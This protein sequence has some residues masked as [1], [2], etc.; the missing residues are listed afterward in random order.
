MFSGFVILYMKMRGLLDLEQVL[1]QVML[2]LWLL[3]RVGI[4]AA[5]VD[6]MALVMAPVDVEIDVVDGED[7][8][9]M[10]LDM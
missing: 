1:A 6:G 10:D 8:V 9:E 5:A 2:Y 3:A 7:P 4:K